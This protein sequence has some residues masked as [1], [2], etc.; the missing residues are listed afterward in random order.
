MVTAEWQTLIQEKRAVRD[1]EIADKST[2]CQQQLA[3]LGLPRTTIQDQRIY[4]VQISQFFQALVQ[5]AAD[6]TYDSN[7]FG[8]SMTTEGYE[9]RIRVVVQNLNRD[10]ESKLDEHGER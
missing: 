4:L 2:V 7:F 6:G 1:G 5:A 9:K 8:D 3:K 10:F